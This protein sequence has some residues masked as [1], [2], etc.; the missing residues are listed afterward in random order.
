LRALT[1]KRS[2]Q[3]PACGWAENL[4]LRM[5]LWSM[6]SELS[7]L[8]SM[9]QASELSATL[10]SWA[11][12]GMLATVAV[13]GMAVAGIQQRLMEAAPE[14][15]EPSAPNTPEAAAPETPV[16]LALQEPIIAEAAKPAA[17]QPKRRKP[18]LLRLLFAGVIAACAAAAAIEVQK[19]LELQ[20][21]RAPKPAAPKLEPAAEAAAP[22]AASA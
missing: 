1:T 3:K 8:I 4:G 11:E 5:S 17:K 20:T 18:L 6:V 7:E 15:Y 14:G 2:P 13:A 9:P 22:A 16:A 12:G 10:H 21:K 19:Q